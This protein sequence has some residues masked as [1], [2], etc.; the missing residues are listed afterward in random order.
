MHVVLVCC[1]VV[2][3]TLHQ[4]FVPFKLGV[5]VVQILLKFSN[6][7]RFASKRG[8]Q[9]SR[10]IQPLV[11][12]KSHGATNKC[13][14]LLWLRIKGLHGFIIL[15]FVFGTECVIKRLT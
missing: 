6:V 7:Y 14:E 5:G 11:V 12:V 15:S 1:L 3:L 4:I 13:L 10:T 2:E 9:I 8:S